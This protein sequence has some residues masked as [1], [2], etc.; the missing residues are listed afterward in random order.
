M[1]VKQNVLQ[2]ECINNSEIFTGTCVVIF[3]NFINLNLENKYE[4]CKQKFQKFFGFSAETLLLVKLVSSNKD[5]FV[6]PLGLS[7]GNFVQPETLKF[8]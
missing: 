6:H 7:K 5:G 4:S 1:E 3:Y 2:L 8:D